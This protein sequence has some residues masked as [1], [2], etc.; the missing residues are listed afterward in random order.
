MVSTMIKGTAIDGQRLTDKQEYFTS[1]EAK[2]RFMN[3]ITA[4]AEGRTNPMGFDVDGN[5]L[6]NKTGP[7]H[8]LQGDSSDNLD[9]TEQILQ[10]RFNPVVKSKTEKKKKGMV[11]VIALGGKPPK[12]PEHTADPDE[13]K[14]MDDAWQF[15]KNMPTRCP[16][17]GDELEMTGDHPLDIEIGPSFCPTCSK[18]H[19]VHSFPPNEMGE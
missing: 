3:M 1:P 6:S 11:V 14:K 2:Q 19:T 13:K 10:D 8:D 4:A 15:L 5:P 17:H 12:S 9:D 16:I 7:R 18:E